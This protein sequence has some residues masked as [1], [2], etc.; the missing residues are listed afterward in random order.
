[1]KNKSNRLFHMGLFAESLR[2]VR[3]MGLVYLLLCLIFAILPPLLG[4]GSVFYPVTG[5]EHAIVLYFYDYIAPVTL[6]YALFGYLTRRNASDFYHSL[7]V[8]REAAYFSR[9]AAIATYLLITTVV[10]VA[11]SMGAYAMAGSAVKFAQLPLLVSY[12]F[13]AQMLVLSCTLVGLSAAGTHFSSVVVTGLALFLPQLI[14]F[15]LYAMIE[16]TAQTVLPET[17][18]FLLDI[19]LNIPAGMI[20][21]LLNGGSALVNDATAY[22][23]YFPAHLYTLGLAAVM[24]L[25]G[26][27]IHNRRRSEIARSAAPNPFLQH[28]YRCLISLPLF[29]IIGMMI[30]SGEE[31]YA[32]SESYILLTVIGLLVYFLYE[33]ITTRKWRNLFG[34][35]KV[36]PLMLIVALVLPWLGFGIG[37]AVDGRV[38]AREKI[39]SVTLD[40]R[41][42]HTNSPNYELIALSRYEYKDEALLDVMHEALAMTVDYYEHNGNYLGAVETVALVDDLYEK[43]IYASGGYRTMD[44]QYNL[45]GGKSEVRRIRLTPEQ[46]N[47]V[48]ELRVKDEGFRKIVETLPEE[49]QI[50]GMRMAGHML[51]AADVDFSDITSELIWEVFTEE[52]AKL[53]PEEQMYISGISTRI[54]SVGFTAEYPIAVD[55]EYAQSEEDGLEPY[56][57]DTDNMLQV[58]GFE[59]LRAFNS[60]YRV[61]TL[62]PETMELMMRYTND[63]AALSG[64]SLEDILGSIN[65]LKNEESVSLYMQ[66][67]IYDPEFKENSEIDLSKTI[68]SEERMADP[69]MA[70]EIARDAAYNKYPNYVGR[71]YLQTMERVTEILLRGSKVIEG[72]D[73]PIVLVQNVSWDSYKSYTGYGMSPVYI[74]LAEED[75]AELM[76][77]VGEY[78]RE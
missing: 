9:T 16:A 4:A 35:L 66:L 10:T 24:L 1:M 39:E 77:V 3:M 19:P 55:Y 70:E 40:I 41:S 59:G 50:S 32:D 74:Q 42:Q 48:F 56:Y 43:D 14:L 61:T 69:D 44:V 51:T 72:V 63:V 67:R 54:D 25:I 23:L 71:E 64:T 20:A 12:H 45:K 22:T 75:F 11:A 6:G 8:T 13:A 57:Y 31:W 49:K 53:T 33:L 7:P 21:Y 2:Q 65:D 36:L 15:I 78:R 58:V 27:V 60:S 38:P 26:C 29:L 5:P 62:T 68:L 28:L 37:H 18:C 47:K 34:A 73:S 30:A 52:Y 46:Y 17:L 76:E